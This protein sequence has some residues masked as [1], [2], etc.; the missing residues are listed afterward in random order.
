MAKEYTGVERRIYLDPDLVDFIQ[1][2]DEVY[3]V[4]EVI[5]TLKA[6]GL[7]DRNRRKRR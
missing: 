4:D 3:S 6:A 2:D 7:T 1:V 5:K